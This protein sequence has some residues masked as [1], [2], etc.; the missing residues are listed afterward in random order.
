MVGLAVLALQ[1]SIE[2]ALWGGRYGIVLLIIFVGLG[3]RV[4]HQGHALLGVGVER[5]DLFVNALCVRH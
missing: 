2:R 3:I 1:S 5:D 4:I